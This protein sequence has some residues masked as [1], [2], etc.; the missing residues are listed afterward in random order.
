M[1]KTISRLAADLAA[2]KQDLKASRQVQARKEQI[3]VLGT[4]LL[5][6]TLNTISH[7]QSQK[8]ALQAQNEM[9]IG[10]MTHLQELQAQGLDAKRHY[11]DGATWMGQRLRNEIISLQK[12][13]QFLIDE[14]RSRVAA[15]D[16]SLRLDSASTWF[17]EAIE[18]SLQALYDQCFDMV[19]A[20]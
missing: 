20:S 1:K 2:A 3:P 13:Y 14:Y 8:N 10:K 17:I 4:E 5:D 7:I 15:I 12:S 18:R 19:E 9:L 6:N 16:G 11:M